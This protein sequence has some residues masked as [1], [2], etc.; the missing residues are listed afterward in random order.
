M[1]RFYKF[2]V[3]LTSFPEGLGRRRQ[4]LL[5]IMRKLKVLIPVLLIRK[6]FVLYNIWEVIFD[7]PNFFGC[8]CFARLL[9][10]LGHERVKKKINIFYGLIRLR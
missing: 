6:L 10:S 8:W 5:A 9:G 3:F 1:N 7:L 4:K 2:S